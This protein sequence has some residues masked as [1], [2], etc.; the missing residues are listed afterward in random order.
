VK[1]EYV[2]EQK[3]L[4]RITGP[5]KAAVVQRDTGPTSGGYVLKDADTGER[6]L[7]RRTRDEALRAGETYVGK[8]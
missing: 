4:E 7:T 6:I 5:H 3:D 1:K 8:K 2:M